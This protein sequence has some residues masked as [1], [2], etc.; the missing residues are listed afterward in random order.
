MADAQAHE[1]RAG[2][3]RKVDNPHALSIIVVGGGIGGLAAG[4]ALAQL[5][6]HVQVCI[7]WIEIFKL[8]L[9]ALRCLV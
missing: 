1:G 7:R 6:H 9:P 3:H 8:R 2:P 4:R 5:G